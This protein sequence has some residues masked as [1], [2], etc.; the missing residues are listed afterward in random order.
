MTE[1]VDQNKTKVTFAYTARLPPSYK[2]NNA[3]LDSG[4]TGNYLN[5]ESPVTNNGIQAKIPDGTILQATHQCELCL[6]NLPPKN[7][8]AHV[9]K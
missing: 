9:F 1:A 7:R 2:N 5:V 4:T 3:I 8:I 6:P